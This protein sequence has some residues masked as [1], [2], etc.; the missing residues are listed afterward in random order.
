MRNP[1]RLLQSTHKANCKNSLIFLRNFGTCAN[2][3]VDTQLYAGH[4]YKNLTTMEWD[5]ELEMWLH[6]IQAFAKRIL[7]K[8]GF[9]SENAV[10]A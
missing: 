4:P 6:F 2:N 9:Q 1:Y 7:L 3:R 5:L 8:T 10:K